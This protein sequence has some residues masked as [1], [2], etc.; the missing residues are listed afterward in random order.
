[1]GK[2]VVTAV[3]ITDRYVNDSPHF[4]PLVEAT[5]KNFYMNEVSADKA[6]LSNGNLHVV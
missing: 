2:A 6:Y 4:A 5:A 3:E 1:L